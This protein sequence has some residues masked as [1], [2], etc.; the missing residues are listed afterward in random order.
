MQSG[1]DQIVLSHL[2]MEKKKKKKRYIYIFQKLLFLGEKNI[3]LMFLDKSQ[4]H[5]AMSRWWNNSAVHLQASWSQETE[6]KAKMWPVVGGF[7]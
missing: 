3:S 2:Y 4:Q 1:L 6:A 5:R 7:S